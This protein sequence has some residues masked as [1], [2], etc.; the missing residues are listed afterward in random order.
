M[1]EVSS[2]AGQTDG[3]TELEDMDKQAEDSVS[4][5]A[6]AINEEDRLRADPFVV[7]CPK[8]G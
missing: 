3:S 7:E 4:L 6:N 8:C 2:V 1:I 5:G